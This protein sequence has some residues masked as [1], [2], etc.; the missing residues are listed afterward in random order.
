MDGDHSRIKREWL[1]NKE[2]QEY[3]RTLDGGGAPSRGEPGRELREKC[4]MK[5]GKAEASFECFRDA[6]TR[7]KA[8]KYGYYFGW[9]WI[10]TADGL[11]RKKH[12]IPQ[13]TAY[14]KNHML[15]HIGIRH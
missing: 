5:E 4:D 2:K 1:D 10:L 8:R 3:E 9:A 12:T 14:Y 15:R 13:Y 11:P 6:K 7:T